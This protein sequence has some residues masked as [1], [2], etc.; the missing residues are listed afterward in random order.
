MANLINVDFKWRHFPRPRLE[1]LERLRILGDVLLR[2]PRVWQWSSSSTRLHWR[3]ASA[4]RPE[5]NHEEA[6]NSSSEEENVIAKTLRNKCAN[7]DCPFHSSTPGVATQQRNDYDIGLRTVWGRRENK[8]GRKSLLTK[9]NNKK[10]TRRLA[11]GGQWS[12]CE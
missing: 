8:G 6:R 9:R 1:R 4:I 7:E 3:W 2:S 11:S 5:I 10:P 12:K